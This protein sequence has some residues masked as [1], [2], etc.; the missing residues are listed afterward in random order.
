M[1]TRSPNVF[2]LHCLW[3][4]DI[5][6]RASQPCSSTSFSISS[7]VG[8]A[9]IA[10]GLR[11]VRAPQAAANF[12]ASFVFLEVVSSSIIPTSC[13]CST[14][15]F[16]LLLL[17][18]ARSYRV[19]MVATLCRR[20]T[21]KARAMTADMDGVL[22]MGKKQ[23]YVHGLGGVTKGGPKECWCRQERGMRG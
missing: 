6:M 7:K 20:H 18:I 17:L 15:P 2:C 1:P 21:L 8:C 9:A 23:R 13:F 11:V 16:T 14:T 12:T 19:Q 5:Q 4:A 22:K 10:P 3:P